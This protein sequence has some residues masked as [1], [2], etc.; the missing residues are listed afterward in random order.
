MTSSSRSRMLLAARIWHGGILAVIVFS[1]VVRVVL[2]VTA[3]P[4][5]EAPGVSP[6]ARIVERLWKLASYYTIESN[7]VVAIVCALIVVQPLRGGRLWEVLRLNSL[8]AIT[9]TG[10]VFAI[11]I[12]PNVHPTGWLFV[13]T[14]GLHYVTPF[15]TALGWLA[16]GPR[17]RFRWSTVLWAYLVAV[18]WLVY[19]FG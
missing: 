7:I 12:A 1:L 10:I 17:P 9:V 8:L 14:V 3:D 5:A 13:A 4:F 6:A 19:I 15:A 2:I 16:F 11:V 18:A